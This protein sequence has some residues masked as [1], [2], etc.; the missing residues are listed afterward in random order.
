MLL[1]PALQPHWHPAD[2]KVLLL[3][4]AGHGIHTA[5]EKRVPLERKWPAAHDA[6]VFH[7]THGPGEFALLK[8][9]ALHGWHRAS[10]DNSSPWKHVQ[11]G[12]VALPQGVSGAKKQLAT[13]GHA[14]QDMSGEVGVH[15]AWIF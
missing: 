2:R 10:A 1:Y 12:L 4:G 6:A 8:N 11:F 9:P 15:R 14:L 13:G 7:S 3:G 5:S